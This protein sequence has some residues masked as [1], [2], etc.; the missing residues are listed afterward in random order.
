MQEIEQ[1]HKYFETQKDDENVLIVVRR[2]LIVYLPAILVAVVVY[3]IALVFFINLDNIGAIA[4]NE[5][6]KAVG[7]TF[8]SIF[9]LFVTLAVYINWLVNYLNVQIVTDEHVVDID[10]VGL[11]S[12]KISELVLVD[13]QDVSATKKGILQ[14]FLN[15]GEVC[16]QTAGERP[17]FNFEKV[18]DPHELARGIME[19]KD[20]YGFEEVREVSEPD[21]TVLGSGAKSS[22]L[23]QEN[24]GGKT[25]I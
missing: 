15:Y 23:E 24:T 5:S 6:L 9:L 18:P 16:I 12:R 19:I 20:K 11:F 13:I 22:G 1:K 14:S 4:N 21:A 17:N 8:S 25:A 2:H 10:Q 3:A 7:V